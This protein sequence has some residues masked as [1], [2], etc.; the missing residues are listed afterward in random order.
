MA[1]YLASTDYPILVGGMPQMT[2][3]VIVVSVV[4]MV[5]SPKVVLTETGL[6]GALI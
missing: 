2:Q 1:R 6:N 3:Y 4:V 5:V